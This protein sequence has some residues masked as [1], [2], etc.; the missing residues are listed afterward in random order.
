LLSQTQLQAAMT[1]SITSSI[2]HDYRLFRNLG[3][4]FATQANLDALD[5]FHTH[6]TPIVN[7]LFLSG[8]IT[9][10]WDTYRDLCGPTYRLVKTNG[11]TRVICLLAALTSP[12]PLC[13]LG[14]LILWNLSSAFF[15]F[16]PDPVNG[17][18]GPPGIQGPQGVAGPPGPPVPTKA[19]ASTSTT[20]STDTSGNVTP[21]DSRRNSL[22]SCSGVLQLNDERQLA[23]FSTVP[24]LTNTS[25]RARTPRSPRV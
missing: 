25:V 12:Y 19:A 20:T 5:T 10:Q 2:D 7:D 16:M 17:A 13:V 3:Q 15:G 23:G 4:L 9:F 6:I 21:A 11:W 8:N 24:L 18:Q 22:D 14:G 1:E